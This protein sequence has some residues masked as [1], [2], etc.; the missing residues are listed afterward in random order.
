VGLA[1]WFAERNGIATSPPAHPL[2]VDT[3][4]ERAFSIG[5]PITAMILGI[6]DPSLTTV[7]ETTALNL[8]SVFRAVS[9]VA[10][11]IKNLT[12]RTIETA[13]DGTTVPARSFLDNPGG[14][15]YTPAEWAEL[16]MVHLL[17]HG[18]AYLQHIRGGAGQL[19]ALYP[20]H[21]T[22]VATTWDDT[23][24]GGK[25]FEVSGLNHASEPF[26]QKFDADSM[27][28][29]MGP[30]LD[31]LVGISA[32][33]A[34]RLSM[35]T[36]VAGERA[37][38]TLF[39]SGAT[40]SGLVTPADNEA[41]LTEEEATTVKAA[42][43]K[44][45]TGTENAGSIAVMSRAL[46]FQSW[47]QSSRDAEFMASRLFSVDE[48]GRWFGV[49][50]HQL[51]LTEKSTSWGQ[52]IAEQ[53]RGFARTTLR[54]WTTEIEQRCSRLLPPSRRAQFD[55]TDYLAPAP[56]DNIR[57]ILAEINGGLLTPNEGRQILNL[58]PLS[59][60]NTLRVPAGAADPGGD[61]TAP[62]VNG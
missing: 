37:A 54:N 5:D 48:V 34:G 29:L 6:T 39:R 53:N 55:Y 17:M 58:A 57:L 45:M 59:D 47:Q 24:P 20:V 61:P 35:G 7:S 42:V 38:N 19:V 26:S 10:G 15:L 2:G 21:P 41:D 25:R 18:N 13:P 36:G 50:P 3:I 22:S 23:R 1:S 60:G 8:S 56:E 28:Q 11:A 30:S 9:L 46:R 12:L 62:G 52:G 27:T 43:R 40:I 33:H 14:D 32:L 51:G 16:V 49:M 44:T 31:G 4:D